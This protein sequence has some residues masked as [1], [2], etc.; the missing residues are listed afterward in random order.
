MLQVARCVWGCRG[1][2]IFGH[3]I[4]L[5]DNSANSRLENSIQTSCPKISA[6]LVGGKRQRRPWN[7]I[8]FGLES[9]LFG[10]QAVTHKRSDAEVR[11]APPASPPASTNFM[12]AKARPD[13]PPPAYAS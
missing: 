13:S 1:T 8:G 3:E 12:R 6:P 4:C 2:L 9:K 11:L 7:F 5:S 10:S